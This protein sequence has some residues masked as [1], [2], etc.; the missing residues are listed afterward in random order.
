MDDSAG[1][2]QWASAETSGSLA[3]V[4]VSTP[5]ATPLRT[6]ASLQTAPGISGPYSYC[7]RCVD[8]V[9]AI[10]LGTVFLPIIA[11]VVLSMRKDGGDI[12]FRHTRI[13]RD[14]KTFQ[15][16]KFRTM[17]PNADEVLRDL[18]SS[19]AL[20][21]D[22][23]IRDHKLK[24]DPRVTVIGG[25]LRRTSLDELPQLWNVLKGEMSLVG[26][27]PI[28]REELPKY[29]RAAR[30]YLSVKPGLT[31]VWQISGRND[32]DYRRRVAMDRHY[33]CT[34]SLSTDLVVL[35]KTV[36]VVLRRRGAY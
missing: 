23:W 16:F 35:L 30:Y 27:R 8:F 12:L 15:V 25:F 24:N 22:E 1:N 6:S 21:R 32:T 28:V 11:V 7:K 33:A 10:V 13:G 2:V 14:G 3:P 18:I 31:G 20:L 26:P 5:W 9:G 4:G 29:G 19:D 36:D 34:A 17:V